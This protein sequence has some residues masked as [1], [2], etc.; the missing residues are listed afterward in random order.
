MSDC[1]PLNAINL[2]TAAHPNVW[3]FAD[4]LHDDMKNWDDRL[5]YINISA[6][7]SCLSGGSMPTPDDFGQAALCAA[8]ATWR[9][10]K[11]VYRFDP[12]LVNELF[13]SA[14]D[15]EIPSEI[16]YQMPAPCIYVDLSLDKKAKDVPDG[17]LAFVEHDTEKKEK[18][19]RILYLK[20]DGQA[21]FQSIIHLIPHGTIYDGL[22]ETKKT[23]RE[24]A[25]LNGTISL[26]V[27]HIN[28]YI[29]ESYSLT[30][31]S[32]QLL[33]YICAENADIKEDEQQIKIFRP[34]S[35][36]LDRYREI[37]KWNV[38]VKVG[39]V[40]RKNTERKKYENSNE[41]NPQ[42]RG[43]GVRP[44]VRRS[45]WHHYWIGPKENQQL[46][47]KWLPAIIVNPEEKEDLPIT[48][49]EEK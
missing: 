5:C 12:V 43:Y 44:H 6:A 30:C 13:A 14:E 37:R 20:K 33:L 7:I 35:K 45:H 9:R 4:C 19:L 2:M 28:Q 41:E 15:T 32:V 10:N 39:E 21:V 17:F 27:E 34:T 26:T 1:A 3:E 40:L 22:Q 25:Q 23:I 48:I 24:N 31:E 11:L 49:I 16:L 38:G 29:D 18:E 42:R 8:L 36:V 47:L 46:V